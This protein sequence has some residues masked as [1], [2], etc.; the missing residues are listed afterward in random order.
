MISA[1]Q[2]W[3]DLRFYSLKKVFHCL[4]AYVYEEVAVKSSALCC[5]RL[6]FSCTTMPSPLVLD[7]SSYFWFFHFS[8][9]FFCIAFLGNVLP[10]LISFF[11]FFF[12]ISDRYTIGFEEII[13]RIIVI[14]NIKRRIVVCRTHCPF[15]SF[16]SKK[17]FFLFKYTCFIRGARVACFYGLLY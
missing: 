2:P 17:I 16:N 15:L 12:F 5:L 10:I 13:K 9:I 1:F 3:I 11:F 8:V 4:D 7:N 6:P 14:N